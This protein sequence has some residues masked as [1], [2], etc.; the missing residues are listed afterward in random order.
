M[1]APYPNAIADF[2]RLCGPEPPED[3]EECQLWLGHTWGG[4]GQFSYQCRVIV[5]TRFMW[6]FHNGPIPDDCDICH[7]CDVGLCVRLKHLW[8]GTRHE[9]MMDAG[10]K[11]H[12]NRHMSGEQLGNAIKKAKA[13]KALE[14][15]KAG[16]ANI[17]VSET[18]DL[19]DSTTFR[20]RRGRHWIFSDPEVKPLTEE[21]QLAIPKLR[22]FILEPK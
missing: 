10:R 20:I 4:R 5:A 17:E 21:E 11:G 8:P 15:F 18:L 3:S 7:T 13:L 9:N 19:S 1:P 16:C 22:D 14:M 6:E 2:F 12:L